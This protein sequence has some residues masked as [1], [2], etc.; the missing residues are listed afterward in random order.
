VD[1]RR[2]FQ[3]LAEQLPGAWYP[4]LVFVLSPQATTVKNRLHLDLRPVDSS[5]AEVKRLLGSASDLPTSVRARPPGWCSPTGKAE[6][7][8]V[9][10][11]L[12][13]PPSERAVQD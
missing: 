1:S 6:H 8:C 4:A 7:F 3:N 12:A 13:P 10:G 2:Q 11:L 9:L 5:E